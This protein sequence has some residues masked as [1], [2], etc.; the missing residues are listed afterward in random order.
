MLPQLKKCTAVLVV[1]EVEPCADFWV[2]RF[3]FEKTAEVPEGGRLGFVILAR[4]GVEI[5]YQ[6]RASVAKDGGK[7][8]DAVCASHTA[9]YI[10]VDDI[11]ATIARLEGAEVMIPRRETF[12]GASEIWV[13]DPAGN[14]A[15]FA[16]FAG[17]PTTAG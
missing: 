15:G 16:M 10:E 1:D 12:Y 2:S 13:L 11:D 8:L 17:A 5:M 4:G 3:G 6:S 7:P 14:Q 9:L